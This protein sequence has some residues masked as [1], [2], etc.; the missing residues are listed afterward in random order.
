M[1]MGPHNGTVCV[2]LWICVC[3]R[4]CGN[5]RLVQSRIDPS[6]SIGWCKCLSTILS[7]PLLTWRIAVTS[8]T[9]RPPVLSVC[10][11]YSCAVQLLFSSFSDHFLLS[12]PS[13][14]PSALLLLSAIF[15]HF[16]F[17]PYLNWA[18]PR[19]QSILPDPCR[20]VF[21]VC[22]FSL[23]FKVKDGWKKGEENGGIECVWQFN[24]EPHGVHSTC[25][26]RGCKDLNFGSEI[27][28][29]I[30]W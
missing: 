15:S 22:W 1:W 11:Y 3:H 4:G 2:C 29:N 21:C 5:H 6:S 20:C 14:S 8:T 10:V 7:L 17:R 30:T 13:P 9:C 26:Q 24:T 12:L 19:E 28:L 27:F 16:C 23:N 18:G 25:I